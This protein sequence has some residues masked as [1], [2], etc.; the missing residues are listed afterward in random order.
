MKKQTNWILFPAVI[1]LLNT[2]QIDLQLTLPQVQFLN[3]D[4]Q[5]PTLSSLTTSNILHQVTASHHFF[6]FLH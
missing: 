6:F 4:E 1:N 2:W 3:L 5:A